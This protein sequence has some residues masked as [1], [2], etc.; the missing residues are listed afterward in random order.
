MLTIKRGDKERY[1]VE[2]GVAVSIDGTGMGIDTLTDVQIAVDNAATVIGRLVSILVE[3]G[4]LGR[5]DVQQLV[6]SVPFVVVEE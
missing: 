5:E 4:L 3:T 2:T 6:G 1:D